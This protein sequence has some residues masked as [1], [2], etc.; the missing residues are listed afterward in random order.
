MKSM[1]ASSASQV[2]DLLSEEICGEQ[3]MS[4]TG[5]A[6]R[7]LQPWIPDSDFSLLED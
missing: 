3:V 5:S 6:V 7:S 2:Q 1:E 4:V